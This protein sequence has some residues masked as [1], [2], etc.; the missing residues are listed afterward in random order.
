MALSSLY[1]LSLY[2]EE[3]IAFVLR[4]VASPPR[5]IGRET[6][7]QGHWVS[8]RKWDIDVRPFFSWYRVSGFPGR[9]V[10][11]LTKR[12]LHHQE[13]RSMVLSIRNREYCK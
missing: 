4:S 2:D 11:E 5:G 3:E 9:C 1:F 12:L 10:Q 6:R 7:R 13:Y 8:Y